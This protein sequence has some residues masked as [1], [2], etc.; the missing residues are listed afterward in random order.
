MKKS[1][2]KVKVEVQ[3]FWREELTKLRCWLEGYKNG[4]SFPGSIEPTIPGFLIVRQIIM[5]IDEA[6]KKSKSK[7]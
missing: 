3:D 2:K 6:K 7:D 1:D 4:R 5:A